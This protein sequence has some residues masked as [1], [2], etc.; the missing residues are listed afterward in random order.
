MPEN[1]TSWNSDNQGVKE[2]VNQTNQTS[3]TGRQKEPAARQWTVQ[4][5]LSVVRQWTM[6]A[7][8]AA[9]RRQAVWEWLT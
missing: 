2:T 3:K 6:Q 7:G 8:L 5:W 1:Q 4:V 9:A